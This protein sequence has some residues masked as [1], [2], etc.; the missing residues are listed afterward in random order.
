LKCPEPDF[1]LERFRP[2]DDARSHVRFGVSTMRRFGSSA[3][4]LLVVIAA[5]IVAL[6]VQNRPPVAKP[7]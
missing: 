5:L 4:M 2:D 6:A 3:L 7:N 1:I